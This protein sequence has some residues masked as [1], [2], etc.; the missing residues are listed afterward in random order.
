MNGAPRS[1]PVRSYVH[2]WYGHLNSLALPLPTAT[3]TPRCTHTFASAWTVPVTSR[4]TTSGSL[5]TRNVMKSPGRGISSSR[6]TQ[7]Q[8]FMNI[9]SFSRAYTSG[10]S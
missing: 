7:S 1:R 4:T 8:S 5:M 10:E 6:A 9:R 3:S 2:A